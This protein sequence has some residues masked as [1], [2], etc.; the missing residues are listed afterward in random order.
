MQIDKHTKLVLEQSI[1]L[2][3]ALLLRIITIPKFFLNIYF[4]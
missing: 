3:K 4:I 2:I 1:L